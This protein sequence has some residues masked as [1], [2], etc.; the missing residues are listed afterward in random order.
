MQ[1]NLV[2][3]GVARRLNYDAANFDFGELSAAARRRPISIF[4]AS[5]CCSATIRANLRELAM[6]Q[7]ASFFRSAA[8]GQKLGVTSRGLSIRTGDPRGEEFP[9]FRAVWIEKGSVADQRPDDQRP[10]RFRQRRR[11]LS[12]H[13]PSRR[14][15]HHRRR[16]LAVPPR[17]RSISSGSR[18]WARPACSAR[19]TG[20]ATTTCARRR[21][22]SPA[23]KCLT[24][25]GEWI[26]RPVSNRT[27]L[28]ISEFVDQNPKGFGFLQRRRAFDDFFDFDAHWELRPSLWIEPIGDWGD[29]SVELVEIPSDNETA[30]NIVAFWRSKTPL[31]KGQQADFAYRQFWCWTPPARPPPRR[32][33][34]LARRTRSGRQAKALP[35]RFP[36]RRSLMRSGPRRGSQPQCFRH[37]WES[38]R[39]ARL[40]G[41]GAQ[42]LPMCSSTSIP[43]ATPPAR[44][45]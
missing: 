45:A 33:T 10:A 28:Q 16:M 22:K 29:G 32:P 36:R 14:R 39:P 20:A 30:Q 41:G 3:N 38:R 17:G 1:I 44:F 43:P 2:E 26:W 8:P 35:G 13:P 21:T 6:F 12:F 23:C 37:P 34:K 40:S 7:G 5:A 24:G 9:L 25:R 11:R 31:V 42:E 19:S 15:H 4:P 18:R 27:T